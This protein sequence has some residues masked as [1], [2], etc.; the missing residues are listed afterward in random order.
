MQKNKIWCG[1]KTDGNA[2]I[3]LKKDCDCNKNDSE[4]N[5]CACNK[6]GIEN[7]TCDCKKNGI[8]NNS[9]DCN[10]ND[11]GNFLVD[12]SDG[13][14]KGKEY[15]CGKHCDCNKNGIKNNFCDC[16]SAENANEK[17]QAGKTKV[18]RSAR[19]KNASE[20]K[21]V[22]KTKVAGS[23]RTKNATRLIT[24][25]AALVAISVVC[26]LFDLPVGGNLK[27][28]FSYI[29][30][31][32]A[33]MFLGPI[34]GL[35]V[36]L[37]GDVLGLLIMSQG[38]WIPLITLGSALMGLIPGL[39]FMIKKVNPYVKLAIALVFAFLIC[40]CGVNSLGIFLMYFKGKKTFWAF[41]SVRLPM[42]AVVFAVNSCMLFLLYYPLEK[43][44]FAKTVFGKK[45]AVNVINNSTQ[46]NM[47]ESMQKDML[48]FT[49]QNM[50]ESIQQDMSEFKN[51]NDTNAKIADKG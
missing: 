25:T 34:A 47:S 27:I 20:K 51:D 2:N 46:Q 50:S 33:G 30:N 41:L 16:N 22:G 3:L 26:N 14:S 19:T 21:Q 45:Q 32:I 1:K 28:S 49:Q 8:E 24:Y 42:Q 35:C 6:N 23:A 12:C 15:C 7:N 10:K 9:C 13:D 4:G 36:G 37:V 48:K 17:M 38:A 18:A 5:T 43:F 39:I 31:F 44:I 40:T 11:G 29:P